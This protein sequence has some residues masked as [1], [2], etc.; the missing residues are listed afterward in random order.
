[1]N[2]LLGVPLKSLFS[3]VIAEVQGM[4]HKVI[5]TSGQTLNPKP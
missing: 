2:L 3:F 1:M 4:K 5:S